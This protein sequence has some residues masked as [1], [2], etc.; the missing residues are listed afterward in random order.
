MATNFRNGMWVMYDDEGQERC[1]ILI[2]ENFKDVDGKP[3]SERWDVHLV[4]LAGDT[5]AIVPGVDYKAL[6]RQAKI[7]EIPAARVS[8]STSLQKLGYEE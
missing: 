7:S 3:S 4:N 8:T 1:G 2:K 6:C 5:K